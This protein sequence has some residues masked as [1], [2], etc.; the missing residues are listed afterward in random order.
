MGSDESTFSKFG[1]NTTFAKLPD[2][3][4]ENA[5]PQV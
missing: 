1:V 5:R 3:P 4:V 2:Y